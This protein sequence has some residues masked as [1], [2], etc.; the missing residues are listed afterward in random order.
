MSKLI[1]ITEHKAIRM[2]GV[3]LNGE[4]FVGIRQMYTTK[5]S[6]GEWMH[7]RQG[8]NIPIEQADKI[9]KYIKQLAEGDDFK[10]IELNKD[11]E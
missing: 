7:G 4:K 10:E 6:E 5:K 2:S 1:K 3:I 9:A 8:I 11:K